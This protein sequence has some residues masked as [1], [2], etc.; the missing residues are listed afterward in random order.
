MALYGIEIKNEFG[1]QTLG[2]QDFTIQKL[3]SMEIPATEGT[4][5]FGNGTRSDYITWTV[6]GY[7][8]ATCFLLITPKYYAGYPQTGQ[9]SQW[10]YLPTYKNLGGNNIAI[11]TYCNRRR[12]TGVGD[13]YADEWIEHTAHAVLEAVRVL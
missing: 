11:F 9:L 6:P 12:P 4:R 13:D 1:V 5:K 3:A 7:D 10:G 8:P 2:M